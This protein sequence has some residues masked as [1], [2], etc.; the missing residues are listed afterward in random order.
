MTS[1]GNWRIKGWWI[2][3][4]ILFISGMDLV[5]GAYKSQ[6]CA[7]QIHQLSTLRLPLK[8]TQQISTTSISFIYW[9][10]QNHG[11][12][13]L[14]TCS[15]FVPP[16]VTLALPKSKAISP[17]FNPS[18][19]DEISSH[20]CIDFKVPVHHQVLLEALS[21][22]DSKLLFSPTSV[23]AHLKSNFMN[24]QFKPCILP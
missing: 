18:H 16:Q 11:N 12:L 14:H 6:R 5:L 23:P 17:V 3:G 9:I 1:R 21:S 4:V 10:H 24:L 2:T 15:W 20:L 8:P 19:I 22:L 13:S 7:S